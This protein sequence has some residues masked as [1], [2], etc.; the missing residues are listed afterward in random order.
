MVPSPLHPSVKALLVPSR[1]KKKKKKRMH[2]KNY[3]NSDS[4]FSWP[5]KVRYP[6]FR[7][8]WAGYFQLSK[9]FRI[10]CK[11]EYYIENNFSWPLIWVGA[12]WRTLL[13]FLDTE[14]KF[15]SRRQTNNFTSVYSYWGIFFYSFCTVWK[16]Y[17]IHFAKIW[18]I[19][20]VSENTKGSHSVD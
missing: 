14:I 10:Q 11:L 2:K 7:A 9:G 4:L 17:K 3:F 1:K 19:F 5:S 8:P 16:V 18:Q 12:M 20:S 15:I 13:C 6:I